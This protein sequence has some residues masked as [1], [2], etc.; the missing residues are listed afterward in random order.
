MQ[1]HRVGSEVRVFT[2]SLDDV[3]ERLPEVVEATLGL[4][5]DPLVLDGEV[6]ALHPDGRPRPFQETA[7]RTGSTSR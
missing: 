7:S 4:A 2:R 1:V 6:I 5:G 3:T